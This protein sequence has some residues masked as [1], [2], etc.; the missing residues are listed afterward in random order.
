MMK[1][2]VLIGRFEFA[3][4]APAP[5]D[6]ETPQT[7]WLPH[8][9][10]MSDAGRTI[11]VL[12]LCPLVGLGTVLVTSSPGLGPAAPVAASVA[13]LLT[14]PLTWLVADLRAWRQ[15]RAYRHPT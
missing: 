9:A 11:L 7:L 8:S 4:V 10:R 5:W 12:A 2:S 1:A 6:V 13:S 3:E 15:D 14:L